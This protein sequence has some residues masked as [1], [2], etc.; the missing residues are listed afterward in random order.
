MINN[1][2]YIYMFAFFIKFYA[3]CRYFVVPNVTIYCRGSVL[4]SAEVV[5]EIDVF[6]IFLEQVI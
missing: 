4:S 3:K 2:I 1:N 6:S 5:F